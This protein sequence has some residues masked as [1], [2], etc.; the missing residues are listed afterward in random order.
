MQEDKEKRDDLTVTELVLQLTK[1]ILGVGSAMYM[2]YVYIN[3]RE[4]NLL[5]LTIPAGLLG[6]EMFN[7]NKDKS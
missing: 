7:R 2:F 1:I 3:I 5:W 4:F 6:I